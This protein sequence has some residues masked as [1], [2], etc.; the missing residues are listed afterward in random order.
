MTK[1]AE[2]DTE[3]P[4][5]GAWFGLYSLDS[6]SAIT[7][8][9]A[10]DMSEEIREVLKDVSKTITRDEKTYYL[11]DV[12]VSDENGKINWANLK[13]EVYLLKELQAPAGYSLNGEI[14]LIQ[15]PENVYDNTYEIVVKN[16]PGH[17]LPESGGIGTMVYTILGTAAMIGSGGLLVTKKRRGSKKSI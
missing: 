7:N 12:Q 8:E 5:S 9:T 15:R 4:L 10:S 16:S 14:W 2:D 6:A 11:T 13:E 3:K 1:V 17:I